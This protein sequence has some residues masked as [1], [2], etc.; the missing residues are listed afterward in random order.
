MRAATVIDASGIQSHSHFTE[1]ASY[2]S[3][4][5]FLV[6]RDLRLRYRQT[7]LGVAWAVLQPLLPMVI[8][9][10]IFS[11]VLSPRTGSLPY[12]LFALAGFAPWNFFA[13]AVTSSA[14]TF[15]NNRNLLAKVYFPRAIL[16][17]AAAAGCLLDWLISTSVTLVLILIRDFR[18]RAS[19][20]LLPVVLAAGFCVAASVGLGMASLIA[21]YRDFRHMLPFMVQVGMYATPIVYPMSLAP[22]RLQL[23]IAL[24]P[25]AGVVE[26]FRSCLFSTAPDW[27][28]IA[29]SSA[30]GALIVAVALT[31][32]FK[33]DADLAEKT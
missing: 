1:Y 6:L 3:L 33:V 32:F 14:L 11:R 4:F 16:P 2:R 8:V 28:V 17:T 12:W 31:V 9:T 24:N 7:V 26:A 25:M 10:L 15:V 18:P 30:T 22:R 19:W 27:T 21:L 13:T 5:W 29:L 23:A 20:L